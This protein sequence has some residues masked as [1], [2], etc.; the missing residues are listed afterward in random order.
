M[1]SDGHVQERVDLQCNSENEAIEL[2][3]QL[4]DGRDVELWQ[5]DRQIR[6]FKARVNACRSTWG[7][8]KCHW[9]QW[10]FDRSRCPGSAPAEFSVNS[11][12]GVFS[13][14]HF[15]LKF[16]R[17]SIEAIVNAWGQRPD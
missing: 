3:K 15:G 2:A 13:S 8:T 9:S 10:F 16:A 7:N 6:T 17:D 4:V 5:L 11:L 1:E 14:C 12:L